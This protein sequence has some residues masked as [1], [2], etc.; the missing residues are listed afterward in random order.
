MSKFKSFLA[1]ALIFGSSVGIAVF[2]V[3]SK[4]RPA[5]SQAS[6]MV[7]LVEYTA[8]GPESHSAKTSG[9]GTTI[10]AREAQLRSEV[11]G[12]VIKLSSKYRPGGRFSRGQTLLN[13]DPRDYQIAVQQQQASV[14]RAELDL[15]L[16]KGRKRVAER[17]FKLLSSGAPSAARTA[18]ILRE[19]QLA[20]ARLALEAAESGLERAVLN[21]ER[22]QLKAPFN[23]F[24]KNKTTDVGEMIGPSTPLGAF[25]GTDAFWVKVTLPIESARLVGIFTHTDKV[26]ATVMTREGG[27][28]RQRPATVLEWTGELESLSKTVQVLVEIKDPLGLESQTKHPLLLGSLVEVEFEGAKTTNI[29]RVPRE[30]VREGTQIFAVDKDNRLIIRD[31]NVAWS[32]RD[33][34]FLTEHNDELTRVVVGKVQL[35]VEGAKLK[36]IEKGTQTGSSPR[37][38][39]AIEAETQAPN[40]RS[41]DTKTPITTAQ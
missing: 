37:A 13:I 30:A 32:N 1:G 17:E 7:Q 31:A 14:G 28:T 34:V 29:V 35:A 2:L 3:T 10:P 40:P 8:V 19:P 26:S 39:T 36:P 6:E 41:V 38:E 22:T 5:R 21:L 23:G 4:K 18:L 20:T 33:H 24:L 11:A 25:V 15:Q 27:E 9:F 16:E 12:R